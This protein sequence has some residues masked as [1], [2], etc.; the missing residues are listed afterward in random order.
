MNRHRSVA[1]AARGYESKASAPLVFRELALL[2]ARLKPLALRRYPDLEEVYGLIL[3]VVELA[4]AH[5]RARAHALQLAGPYHRRGADAVAVF[6]RAGHDVSDYLHVAVAVRAE[7]ARGRDDVLVYD[8]QVAEARVPRVV[9]AV[10][11]E[12]VP[13]V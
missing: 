7:A 4:V 6:E 2:V 11:G 1:A 5:A 9:V 10:E 13:A 3:R 8:E 12:R